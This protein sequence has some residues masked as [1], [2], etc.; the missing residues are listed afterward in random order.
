MRFLSMFPRLEQTRTFDIKPCSR[1]NVLYI[2]E[3]INLHCIYKQTQPTTVKNR[4]KRN[5]NI[6]RNPLGIL[7]EFPT[8]SSSC[9]FRLSFPS[10]YAF[11]L[12]YFKQELIEYTVYLHRSKVKI[13]LHIS[14]RLKKMLKFLLLLTIVTSTII[15]II[16]SIINNIS[17]VLSMCLTLS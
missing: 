16:T 8:F 7:T 17:L 9:F 13:E 1:F 5:A 12:Y 6:I 11:L 4:V 14:Q 10:T 3:I 2:L 15:T